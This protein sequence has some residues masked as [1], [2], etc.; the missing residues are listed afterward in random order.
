[1]ALLELFAD[2]AIK[3]NKVKI[4]FKIT[5]NRKVKSNSLDTKSKIS[6]CCQLDRSCY[7]LFS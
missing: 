3:Y 7:K 2:I 5:E 6:N 4:F 1:M